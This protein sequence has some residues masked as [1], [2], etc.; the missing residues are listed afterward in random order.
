MAKRWSNQTSIWRSHQTPP[1]G[2]GVQ[3]TEPGRQVSVVK[4]GG[5]AVH[6]FLGTPGSDASPTD[7]CQGLDQGVD[8]LT[9]RQFDSCCLY[10]QHGRNSV[11]GT[12]PLNEESVD[13]VLGAQHTNSS[14]KPPRV[15]ER[16]SGRGEPHSQGSIRLDAEH[17]SVKQDKSHIQTTGSGPVCIEANIPTT[18]I[19]QL[20]T[21][22]PSQS[23]GC[24]TPGLGNN[25]GICQLTMGTGG[26]SASPG[27]NTESSNS[28]CGT[29]VEGIAMVCRSP[30]YANRSFLVNP[31]HAPDQHQGLA[32]PEFL[33]QLAVWH[34]SGR[35]TPMNN[36]QRR[37]QTSC[38]THGVP[39]PISL[40]THSL[41]SGVAG[42]LNGVQIPFLVV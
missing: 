32:P 12:N 29:C 40:T 19:L 34:I 15:L 26:S 18:S 30:A 20:E 33:P 2:V 5:T 36:Y 42:V 25:Q 21:R 23:Y 11:E 31:L 17:A 35:S 24:S 22:S 39:R 37:L 8:S 10:Q 38:L 28:I 7:V 14:W 6:K 3:P 16:Y 27:T 13:M 4:P 41:T 9:P 1:F